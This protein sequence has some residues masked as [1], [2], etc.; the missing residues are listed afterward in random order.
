MTVTREIAQRYMDLLCEQRFAEAFG[1][2]AD[3]A[4]YRI[5]GTTD[6]SVPFQ[7]RAAVLAALVPA[8][9]SCPVPLKLTFKELIVEGDR[10]VGL[11]SGKGV[12]PTGLPY[13]QPH[14]AMVL[15]IRDGQIVSVEEYA[16]TV[17]IEVAFMGKKLVAA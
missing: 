6:I 1:L 15:R 5:I 11:A 12:G 9:D 10:A 14:Y 8:L 16:D 13:E 4:T 2:L 7:G 17:A 3:D